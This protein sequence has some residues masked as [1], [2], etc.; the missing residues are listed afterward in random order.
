[1]GSPVLDRA[2]KTWRVAWH[3]QAPAKPHVAYW[4]IA[5]IGCIAA[6][7]TLSGAKRTRS[8]G[9]AQPPPLMTHRVNGRVY[10]ECLRW[11]STQTLYSE[12]SPVSFGSKA[13]NSV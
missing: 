9:R 13:S 12:P 5:T 2:D 1:M 7:R 8:D 3:P 11:A 6:I 4:P 10:L